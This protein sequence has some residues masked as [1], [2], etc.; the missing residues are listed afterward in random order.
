[1]TKEHISAA[2]QSK[3]VKEMD[4]NGEVVVWRC[5]ECD[6]VSKRSGDLTK[7]IQ[8]KHMQSP[9]FHCQYC[10]KFCPSKNALTSHV[11]RN[12]R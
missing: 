3:M 2:V 6:H 5:V 10:D 4:V 11:S 7:H 1:M 9:G 8:A 12:H